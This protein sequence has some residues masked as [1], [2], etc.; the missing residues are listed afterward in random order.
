MRLSF[1]ASI[2]S[3]SVAAACGG[4]VE[5]AVSETSTEAASSADSADSAAS[6]EAGDAS[7]TTGTDPTS[8]PSTDEGTEWSSG[9]GDGDPTTTGTDPTTDTSTGGDCSQSITVELDADVASVSGDWQHGTSD[10]VPSEG[11]VVWPTQ[12]PGA[13]SAVFDLDFPCDDDWHIWVKGMD[14]DQNDSFFARVDGGPDP[15]A[16]FD[17]DCQPGDWNNPVYSWA[18]LNQRAQGS[19]CGLD[20]LWVVSG[21]PGD[22]S[23]E[24]IEREAGAISAVAFSND[25][26][27]VPN[28]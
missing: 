19:Y 10:L 22:G 24:F 16:I 25:P 21:G 6:G 27:Y 2:L 9:D 26:S 28:F 23:V 13:G 3:L 20:N 15:A 5:E 17:I 12:Q 1:V 18:H 7:T 14:R 11:F 8:D 4:S